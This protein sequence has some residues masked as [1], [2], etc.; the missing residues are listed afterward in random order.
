MA[1]T[2]TIQEV[3]D[4]WA[5]LVGLDGANII[6]DDATNFLEY[7]NRNTRK[8]WARAEWTF[9]TK[10]LADTTDSNLFVDLSSNAEI[11]EVLRVYDSD[12]YIATGAVQLDFIPVRDDVD[13]GLFVPTASASTALTVSSITRASTTATVTTSSVHNLS[14]GDSVEIIGAAETD[15]NGFYVVTVTSTTA[16][17]YTVDNSPGTPATGT[18]TATKATVFLFVRIRETV[19]TALS[20]TVPFELQDYL[21]HASAADFLR[22]EGQ[23]GKAKL[24]ETAAELILLDEIDRVERQQ[25]HQPPTTVNTRIKG[26]K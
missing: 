26:R 9:V 24:E 18:I 1:R 2:A 17:T 6:T 3:R 14:T 4:R 12:P 13:D 11:S 10:R 22:S 21:A 5:A 16:F 25:R 7:V 15:Y 20:G 8:A 19:Q 23:N